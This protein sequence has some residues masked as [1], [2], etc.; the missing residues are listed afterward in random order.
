M[1]LFSASRMPYAFVAID[2]SIEVSRASSHGKMFY[3]PT[4]IYDARAKT[5]APLKLDASWSAALQGTANEQVG[6]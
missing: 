2:K 5:L 1:I 3:D 6:R 4:R